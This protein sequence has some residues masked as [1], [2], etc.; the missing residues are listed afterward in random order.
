MSDNPTLVIHFTGPWG[1]YIAG[2]DATLPEPFARHLVSLGVARHVG[3]G[4]PEQH[5]RAD[6]AK[7]K[8]VQK[9]HK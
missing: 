8:H 7:P 1:D 2:Q 6:A 5:E 3:P 9:A 4:Q